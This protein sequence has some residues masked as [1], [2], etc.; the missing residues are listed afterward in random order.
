CG[1]ERVLA[2]EVLLCWCYSFPSFAPCPPFPAGPAGPAGKAGPAGPA[3]GHEGAGG[4]V[5]FADRSKALGV[6]Y[7]MNQL[8][9]SLGADR[10]ARRLV[11]A[12]YSCL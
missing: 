12:V 7:V 4:S 2:V 1:R 5:A 10:R 11:E 8:T 6:A 9:A 3:F